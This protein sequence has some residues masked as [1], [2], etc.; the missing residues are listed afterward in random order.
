MEVGAIAFVV[1]LA[2][3]GLLF[4]VPDGPVHTVLTVLALAGVGLGT[5]QV[6][7]WLNQDRFDRARIPGQDAHRGL[8]GSDPGSPF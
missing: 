8:R 3:F 6:F 5:L 2:C 4:L 7:G 1:D